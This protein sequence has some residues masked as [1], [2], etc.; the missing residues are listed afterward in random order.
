MAKLVNMMLLL[1]IFFLG[2]A[3]ANCTPCTHMQH[4][5]NA[6]TLK[7]MV[8]MHRI[9]QAMLGNACWNVLMMMLMIL[10]LDCQVQ[11]D[12]TQWAL[13]CTLEI[14]GLWQACLAVFVK[15][16]L[17]RVMLTLLCDATSVNTGGLPWACPAECCDV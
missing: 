8:A 10:M 1:T 17:I 2:G 16:C 14:L 4:E 15:L 6:L 7:L 3:F 9:L 5:H 11:L 12:Q 13:D